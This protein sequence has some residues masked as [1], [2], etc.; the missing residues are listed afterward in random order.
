[1]FFKQWS[2]RVRYETVKSQ[3]TKEPRAQAALGSSCRT[4]SEREHWFPFQMELCSL[5]QS[6]KFRNNRGW[7]GQ[8]YFA[9]EAKA[10]SHCKNYTSRPHAT[11]DL[12]L[13]LAVQKYNCS[14][15]ATMPSRGAVNQKYWPQAVR[16][17]RIF[18]CKFNANSPLASIFKNHRPVSRTIHYAVLV[19]VTKN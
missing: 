13:Q 19:A 9:C 2:F 7:N 17:A 6:G 18:K 11:S 15:N 5:K 14:K 4:F 8:G 10:I 12:A 3:R 16:A 1:M